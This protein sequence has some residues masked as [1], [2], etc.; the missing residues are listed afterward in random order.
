M[1]KPA[2][3]REVALR[4]GVSQA[5]VSRAMNGSAL[6]SEKTKQRIAA[7][8]DELGFAPSLAARRLSLGKTLTVTVIVSFLTR[9]RQL[10]G[11]EVSTLPWLTASSTWSSTTSSRSR[12]A[13]ST[14]RRCPCDSGPTGC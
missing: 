8:A 7:V 4:A 5:T 2:T 6:V 11:C 10:S 14:S 3:I 13:I 1:S 12:S 9:P